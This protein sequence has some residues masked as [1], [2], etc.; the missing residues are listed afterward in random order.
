MN[1]SARWRGSALAKGWAGLEWAIGVP[2]TV[3]GA[4]V[5]NS[6]AHGSDMNHNLLAAVIWEP[7]RGQRIYGNE[8]DELRYRDSVLKRE[9]GRGRARRVVLSAELELTPEPVDVLTARADGFTAH[10]K[11]T[12]PGGASSRLDV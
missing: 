6:G 5:G 10:R 11:Q 1:L 8:R 12:Q 3:G 9:Q 7:G 2:G 4:V